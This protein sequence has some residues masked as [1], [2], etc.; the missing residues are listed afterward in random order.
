M[1]L[2]VRPM[3][4]VAMMTVGASNS[5]NRPVSRKYPKAP[6]IRPDA[7]FSSRVIVVSA[8]T[9]IIASGSPSSQRVLL[10]QGDDPLLQ[11]ADHLQAGT[12]AHVREPRVL[13]PAE[14][15]LRDLAVRCPVEQRAPRL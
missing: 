9:R 3:P 8:N 6:A 7:S 13:V 1:T 4:P 2:Y 11:G 14:V 15:P 5:T 10:L 12:V